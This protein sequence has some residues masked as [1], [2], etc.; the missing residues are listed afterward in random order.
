M[1]DTA[2]HVLRELGALAAARPG[3]DAAPEVV[4]AWYERKAALLE[5]IAADGQA[6][7]LV[8]RRW[9]RQARLRAEESRRRFTAVTAVAV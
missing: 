2:D 4:A 8:T 7:A 9:A 1:T 5:H 3:V 6:D